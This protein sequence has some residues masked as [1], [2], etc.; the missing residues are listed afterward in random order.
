M[1]PLDGFLGPIVSAPIAPGLDRYESINEASFFDDALAV[2]TL[3]VDGVDGLPEGVTV[4]GLDRMSLV[5]EIGLL[6]APDLF[7]YSVIEQ[8]PEQ[9][10]DQAR[11][12][13][14]A[15]CRPEEPPLSFP[16]TLRATLLDGGTQLDDILRRQLRMVELAERQ[17]RFVALLDVP[18]HLP[19]RAIARWRARFDSTYA[20]AYHPWLGVVDAD[21]PRAP[22]PPGT[23][24]RFR[25][26]HHRR[27]GAPAAASRGG[28]RTRSPSAPCCVADPVTDADHDALHLLGINVF[29][30]ER[31]G[32]RLTSARTLRRRPRLPPAQ[33][34]PAGHHA[35]ADAGPA[36]AVAGVRAERDRSCAVS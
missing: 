26:R 12:P 9:P 28:R 10:A 3:P 22:G 29:R 24:V 20:A 35:P 21:D 23:A 33:R 31:D 8:T 27:A 7:W 13:Q 25:R 4:R 34:P 17:Q 15:T 2:V 32:L 36:A 6:C 16:P 30:A 1:L 5:R 11:S 14:F 19:V 18:M